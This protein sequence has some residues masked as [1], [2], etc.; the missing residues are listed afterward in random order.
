MLIYLV[1]I[2]IV[3]ILIAVIRAV[4]EE[5][6]QEKE[7]AMAI[8]EALKEQTERNMEK[9]KAEILSELEDLKSKVKFNEM[10][11]R[12]GLINQQSYLSHNEEFR[13]KIEELEER[14]KSE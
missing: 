6:Q 9:K 13:K 10:W 1:L 5:K 8:A 2:T 11:Y 12:D 7:K 14:W 4:I 3:V